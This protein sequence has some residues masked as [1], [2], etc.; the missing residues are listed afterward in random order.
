MRLRMSIRGRVCPS[1][2]ASFGS[3]VRPLFRRLVRPSHVIFEWQIRSDDEI[4]HGPRDSLG[5]SEVSGVMNDAATWLRSYR[6]VLLLRYVYFL[7]QLMGNILYTV[8]H[9]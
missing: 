2:C 1:V 4:I 5:F 7:G 3:L 6:I 8:I 9:F